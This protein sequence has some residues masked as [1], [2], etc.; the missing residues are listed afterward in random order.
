MAGY[1]IIA[2]SGIDG[3]FDEFDEFIKP[4]LF[5]CKCTK[6]SYSRGCS[7]KDNLE[8]FEATIKEK[9]SICDIVGWSIG[10]VAAGFLSSLTNVDHV[11]MINPFFRRSEIL[12]M[13]NIYCDEEVS[14][15][16]VSPG[17]TTEYILITG[18]K[19]NKIPYTESLR[20]VKH[21]DLS[22]DCV[23]I[24][25]NAGHALSSFPMKS[26]AQIIN[27]IWKQ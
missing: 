22:Q 13:R 2:I 5:N 10:G 11:I 3:S 26:I 1:N 27:G 14:L 20:I 12:R 7:F 4:F 19:D 21:F 24:F 16:D 23:N 9:E 17:L 25:E 15:S 6:L 18:R 8:R